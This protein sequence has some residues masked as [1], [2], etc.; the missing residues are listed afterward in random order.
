[1]S[2]PILHRACPT[3]P[4]VGWR[5][6]PVIQ[7]C[8]GPISSGPHRVPAHGWLHTRNHDATLSLAVRQRDRR[9]AVGQVVQVIVAAQGPLTG[10]IPDGNTGRVAA[11]LMTPMALPTDLAAAFGR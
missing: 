10:R 7:N 1:M 6:P 5:A 3:R 4:G 2:R 11:E 8:T 9:E